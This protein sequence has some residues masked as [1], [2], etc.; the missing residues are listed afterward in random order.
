MRLH[1]NVLGTLPEP[2]DSDVSL[3]ILGTYGSRSRTRAFEVALRGHG[4]RHKR[5]PN[6]GIYGASSGPERAAT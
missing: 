1:T 6:T 5:P 2:P 4:A 3:H